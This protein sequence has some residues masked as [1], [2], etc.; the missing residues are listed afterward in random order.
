[1]RNTLVV[2][3]VVLTAVA[4]SA[5]PQKSQPASGLDLASF[6]RQVR[7]QDDLFQFAN[8][9]WLARTEIPADRV[10]YSAFA[11]LVDRADLDIRAIVE[12]ITAEGRH[13]AGSTAQQIA[14]L[15][16]SM[17][18]QALVDALGARPL[19]PELQRIDAI[20]SARDVAAEA[21]YLSSVGTGGP[22]FATVAVEAND[23][24]ATVV[25]VSQG[26]LLL[27]DRDHYL[28][29]DPAFV[30]I[31]AKYQQFLVTVFSLAGRPNPTAEAA[32]V[33][34]LETAIARV[35]WT[36][37]DSRDPAKTQNPLTLDRLRVDMPG[38]DWAA[39]ARP[40]GLDQA[41]ALVIAQPSFFKSFAA[42]V[43]STPLAAW[44]AWLAARYITAAA[45]YV[46]RPFS[47][48]RFE[49]FGRLLTGQEAPRVAWKRGVGLV[50]AYLG[51]AV[52]RLYVAQHF[53]PAAKARAQK[54]VANLVTA[55]RQSIAGLE[56]MS[57]ATKTEAL[58]KL[59]R[60]TVKIGYPDTWR[61][62]DGL[63]VRAD[64][65]VGNLQRAQKFDNEYR[66][67]RVGGLADRGEWPMTPQT[68]NA[69]YS[70]ALNELVVPAAFLQPPLFDP[71]ADDAVNYG[72]I[73]SVIGHEISHGF[74]D[75][76]RQI[77]AAGASRLWWTIADERAYRA[78]TQQLAAQLSAHRP[79]EGA[80]LTADLVLGESLSDLAGLSVAFQ[81]YERS[82]AGKASPVLDGFT[83]EQR[84]FLGW[85]QV[86]RS[87]T[88]E[89]YLRQQLPITPYAPAEWRANGPPSQLAGF[90]QAFGL[91][92][93]DRL[94]RALNGRVAIW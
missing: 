91:A 41:R 11:E 56:W 52:G 16:A 50:N 55:F 62:Y 78:R 19:M 66:M 59:S 77:D 12:R 60:L 65:L 10:S 14:D 89:A 81:A 40:Q 54:V 8:G 39:W 38:F 57:P 71:A 42:M 22:F 20:K 18:N 32:D 28:R 76:G 64:D 72:A 37:E 47:D 58:R 27:P 34:A 3:T 63:V 13:R 33:L 25:R 9:G 85:A 90:H 46:S 84:F 43:P 15:Y 74:D 7:P 17:T 48:A 75:Q 23:P 5:R 70:P 67:A 6:D 35:Q 86:W 45:P 94:Y 30:E 53:P 24:G 82:L 44:K 2:A 1:M 93:G 26:G 79:L 21:G 87:K 83:G 80:R 69:F 73:G 51:Q 31:R 36:A 92:P 29:A 88:R 61:N 4:L 68:V 49:F